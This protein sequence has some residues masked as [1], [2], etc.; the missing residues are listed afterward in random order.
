MV[1]DIVTDHAGDLTPAVIYVV[2]PA[3][4]SDAAGAAGAGGAGT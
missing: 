3:G 2:G 4:A 1:I